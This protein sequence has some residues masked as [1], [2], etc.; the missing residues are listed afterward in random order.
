MAIPKSTLKERNGVY[1]LHYFERGV[2]KRVSLETGSLRLAQDKQRQ[3]DSARV[4]GG[5]TTLATHTPLP[6]IVAAYL[7]NMQ[8]RFTKSG[9][10]ADRSSLRKI[11]GPI[12]PEL[13][14]GRRT[15]KALRVPVDG[16]LRE[17]VI[18]A[19]YL[20]EI[21]TAQISEFILERVRRH[22]LQPKTAN[23][24]R[25][26]IQRFFNWAM[27]ERGVRMPGGINP[28]S[29]VKRY[30]E[31]AP[32]IRFLTK[33]QIQGQLNTLDKHP[34]L[35]TMVALYI[36]AGLRR[37]EALWLTREDIDLKAGI[38]GVIRVHSKTIGGEFW[39]PKTKVNRAVPIS[40]TLRG[41]LDEYETPLVP[42]NW[43]FSTPTG[44]RWNPDNFSQ[45]L[46]KV[47][48]EAGLPWG[49]L[50]FRHTFGSQLAM[51]GE[52]LYKI[53]TLMG[54]SPEICRRHYATLLPESLFQSV[55]FD[56]GETVRVTPKTPRQGHPHLRLIVKNERN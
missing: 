22:N 21:T 42:D 54:N 41:Y 46:R 33:P 19:T 20:E 13:D 4:R 12:C 47:N 53:S 6:D 52:S 16:R 24:Y 7:R 25:E 44:H 37:E 49:C 50:D 14:H 36:Y 48:Q 35:R 15:A 17:P 18:A 2:R 1:Y 43:F 45:Y 34:T 11:F 55:E 40:K 5:D 38:N 56:D 23:R 39:E 26:L 51:K 3:F 10:A 32:Q 29:K 8:T 27:E 31:R 9:F 30:P 28:A